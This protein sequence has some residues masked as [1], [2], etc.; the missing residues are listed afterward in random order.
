MDE[1]DSRG[2][3]ALHFAIYHGHI[4]MVKYVFQNYS[5]K[6]PEHKPIYDA[7]TCSN[8]IYLAVRS[9][10]PEL[11]CMVLENGLFNAQ[12]IKSGLSHANKARDVDQEANDSKLRADKNRDIL[13][14]LMRSG[15]HS[16]TPLVNQ[17]AG[18]ES[19][20]QVKME[21]QKT[22]RGGRRGQSTA[23]RQRE[24]SNGKREP[25]AQLSRGRGQGYHR[26]RGGGRA[27]PR[28]TSS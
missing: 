24:D 1:R 22:T 18:R 16:P 7:P 5:P 21:T 4:P 25:V 9:G 10:E 27:H 13:K 6:E 17:S 8:L 2:Y 12:D 20:N 11:V 28:Q 14:L 23:P 15:E 19:R 26:R 3:T